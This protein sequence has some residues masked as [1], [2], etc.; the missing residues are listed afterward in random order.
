MPRPKR[1]SFGS[2]DYHQ[3]SG[4]SWEPAYTREELLA[5]REDVPD[6]AP[7]LQAVKRRGAG[8]DL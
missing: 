3:G 1:N 2:M 7:V 4:P 8:V 5:I 6:D